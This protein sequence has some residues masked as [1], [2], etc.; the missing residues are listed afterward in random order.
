MTMVETELTLSS[1]PFKVWQ[2]LVAFPDYVRW[3]PYIRLSGAAELGARTEYRGLLAILSGRTMGAR[4]HATMPEPDF[5]LQAY[6]IRAG[7]KSRA[8]R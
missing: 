5:A 2:A 6:P 8:G 4:T 7:R 1:P 3:H